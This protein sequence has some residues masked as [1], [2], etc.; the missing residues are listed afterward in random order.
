[1]ATLPAAS[2]AR[3]ALEDDGGESPSKR[4]RINE[5]VAESSPQRRRRE[6]GGEE[7]GRPKRTK[8]D[9][10]AAHVSE[11]IVPLLAP[12]PPGGLRPWVV[13]D[14][15]GQR[16]AQQLQRL[17]DDA[18]CE[19]T[20]ATAAEMAH[21]FGARRRYRE[22]E[23]AK[24]SR[25]DAFEALPVS[26][27]PRGA[28]VFRHLWVDTETKSR[29]TV[30]DRK[31]DGA[32][33]EYVNVPVPAPQT[34][35]IMELLCVVRG[36]AM[37]HFDVVSA[38]PHAQEVRDD[39]FVRPPP[40]W[41]PPSS[42]PVVWRMRQA[43]YGR[44]PAGANFRDYFERVV[45]EMRGFSFKRGIAEPA[46]YHDEVSGTVLTHHI[47]DGRVCADSSVASALFAG[48]SRHLVLK[49][50][51]AILEG[52]GAEYL[53]RLRLR[54][55]RGWATAPDAKHLENVFALVG[56]DARAP[57]A[58]TSTPG[59][60]RPAGAE[61]EAE[62]LDEEQTSRYR[63]AVG[64]LVYFSGDVAPV[65][66]A[67]K[68]LARR[69]HAPTRQDWMDLVRCARFLWPLRKHVVFNTLAEDAVLNPMRVD[70]HHDS[71]WAG[72][73]PDR[74]SSSGILISVGGF[75]LWHSSSTQPGLPALSSGEA[76]LRCM[77]RAASEGLFVKHVLAELGIEAVVT[78][79]GDS[80]AA[81]AN[82]TKLGSG[83]IRHLEAQEVF[84]KE[85]VRLRLLRLARV[86]SRQN[87]ANILTKHVG[88]QELQG[89]WSYFGF[90][91]GASL[92]AG[93]RHLNQDQISDW[94]SVRLLR[95]VGSRP[96]GRTKEDDKDEDDDGVKTR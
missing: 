78:L 91:D 5:S 4:P 87:A 57:T 34:N 20:V 48:L 89:W 15:V 61:S 80:A 9:E 12:R 44:R 25:L 1:M 30:Q 37:Y 31:A 2:V 39:I 13:P 96:P 74:R 11:H 55:P 27:L 42:E 50:S 19:E 56:F 62:P 69:L 75:R 45:C 59:L 90:L 17:S 64:S 85:A 24:L 28:R 18:V 58:K 66:F 71:D 16:A 81:L 49:I 92:L 88:A 23:L 35:A 41:S 60:K 32:T 68:E 21:L 51:P 14:G 86:P 65:A 83:R 43:L 82:A 70:V 53:G 79:H 94:S 77:S 3:P 93:Y 10:L 6:D 67:I 84:V 46:A 95:S 36:W 33:E 29:L 38:F 72:S 54:I 40:E 7:A 47:D 73:T 76:E 22:E 8:A 26:S 63:S 52:T